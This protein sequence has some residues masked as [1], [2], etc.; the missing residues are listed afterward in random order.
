MNCLIIRPEELVS[1]SEACLAGA[2]CEHALVAHELKEGL[3]VRAAVLD[4]KRGSA[5]VISISAS[6]ICLSLLLSEDALPR[7]PIVWI[8]AVARPQT[9]KKVLQLAATLG[10]EELHLIRTSQVVK[11]YLQSPVLEPQNLETE[12][13]KGL[14]QSGD[15]RAPRVTLHRFFKPFIQES[16]PALRASFPQAQCVIA[17]TR[18]SG[19]NPCRPKTTQ[20]CILAV[21]PESGWSEDEVRQFGEQGFTAISLGERFLRVDTACIYA[22]AAIEALRASAENYCFKLRS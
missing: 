13:L 2:R 19:G 22:T 17:D 1:S 6:K 7:I 4:G 9:T 11:S 3:T 14:E 16:L 15:S 20:S 21:G 12:I 18:A 5:K 8:V 10:I